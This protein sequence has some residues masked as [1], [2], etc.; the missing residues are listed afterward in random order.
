[1]GVKIFEIVNAKPIKIEELKGK[2]I[3]VDA[4]LVLYQFLASIRQMDGKLLTDSKG[5]VTSHLIGLLSRTTNMLKWEIKPVYIFDGKPPEL[6]HQTQTLRKE[7]KINATKLYEEATE[8]GDRE[9]MRK[10]GSRTSKLTT[11]M[12]D[13][14]KKLLEGL[15]VPY[16]NA[17]S[18][19]EA[20]ASYMAKKGDAWAIASQDADSFLFGAPK[21]IRN[22]AVGNKR[23]KPGTMT[24][25]EVEPEIVLLK[26]LLQELKLTQDQ[27]IILAML[28]GTDYNP[29]GIHGI[30]AKKALKLVQE[31]G[32][33]YD[34]L[35]ENAKWN[36][37]FTTSWKEV[38][39]TFKQIPVTDEYKLEWKKPNEKE[40]LKLLA[41][42]HDFSTDRVK[43]TTEQL[44]EITNKRTQKG[45]NDW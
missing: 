14:A 17:P 11:Q 4:S 32:T 30:G 24:Y 39:E 40:L 33:K 6:K 34:A 5:N 2:I 44:T 42:E 13:E 22:L 43:K 8:K 23:K 45:L 12:C 7:T 3:A 28:V 36:E 9:A 16:V 18:E 10:Y 1:M 38:F 37:T 21:V 25:E 41:E 19:A 29:G 27:L 26:E 31:Y 20:Q 35:F 15:G